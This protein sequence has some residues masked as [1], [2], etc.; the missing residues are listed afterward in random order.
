MSEH[1]CDVAII[2]GGPAGSTVGSFL[3]KY[4]PELK[5][6][7]LER[8]KFPRDHVGESQLP[9][10]GAILDEIGCWE[11]VEAANFPI[12]IGATYRWGKSAEL[13]DFDF[14]PDKDFTDEERP[15]KF[16]GQRQQTAFQVD[17][18]VYDDILL[19]HAEE[20]GCEVTEE[21][22]VA[23]VHREGDRVTGLE[24]KDGSMLT[25]K[26]YVD[27]SGHAGILRRA[28]DVESTV[29]T[30]LKNIAIYD[31]W[32]NAEWATE[33]GV[34]GTRVQVM[35]QGTGWLWFIP[36]SPTRTSIGFVCPADYYKSIEQDAE[37]LYHSI[38]NSDERVAPLVK[39]AT[40]RGELETVKDWSFMS[41][42][43]AGENWFLAGEAAGFADPVLAAGLT[44]TH[45]SARELGYVLLELFRGEQDETWLKENYDVTQRQRIHQHIR[46]ADF[47]YANNGQFT[48]LQEQC[49]EIAKEAGLKMSP[50]AAWAWLA[51]GG[52][53]HDTL[54]QPGIGSID[55]AAL[56]QITQLFSKKK[57]HWLLNQ[58]NVFKLNLRNA[59]EAFVPKFAD[60]RIEKIQCYVK[61]DQRL[62][63]TGMYKILVDQL[64]Q[65]SDIGTL[66]KGLQRGFAQT[67]VPQ[68]AQVA[69][70]QAVQ[71]L[72]VM[73]SEGWVDAKLSKKKPK[74]DLNT[75]DEGGM[76]HLNKDEVS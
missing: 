51:Q 5:V 70:T 52:F 66:Y 2:G 61:G 39:N 23:K 64:R 29:P 69:L 35:S 48:D 8:E 6:R 26:Y 46:F 75:P 65:G 1:D 15:A 27:A 56:K 31:Y 17:R 47:W 14:L 9:P 11:K 7:I 18:A 28:M 25:A 34:G 13:W 16:E 38:V 10:I 30:S 37:E 72:E 58:Y 60:G 36:L 21:T 41:M 32:E 68:H 4:N 62:P 67:L 73:V 59:E 71:T 63:L 42:R 55:L 49:A 53:T 22:G 24:L 20:F 33:I 74:L 50:G 57:A 40:C 45:T 19:R 3:R 76:I 43:N 44:L 12:K 54:G